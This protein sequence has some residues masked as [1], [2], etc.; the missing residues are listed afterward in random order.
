MATADEADQ[1]CQG[2]LMNPSLVNAQYSPRANAMTFPA[3]ILQE[4][5]RPPAHTQTRCRLLNS[6]G[7]D[8]LCCPLVVCVVFTAIL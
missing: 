3:A 8:Q 7:A 2:L 4:V 5:S 6:W 1:S